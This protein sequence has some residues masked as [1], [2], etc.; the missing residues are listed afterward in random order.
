[1]SM[2]ASAWSVR[3]ISARGAVMGFM[4][5]RVGVRTAVRRGHSAHFSQ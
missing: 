1:M 5:A 2:G 3:G 4:R